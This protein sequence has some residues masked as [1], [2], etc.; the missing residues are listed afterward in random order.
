ME[1]TKDNIL[2]MLDS[3]QV[4]MDILRKEKDISAKMEG[5]IHG[6]EAALNNIRSIVSTNM[7]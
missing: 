3:L 2:K 7:E 1:L 4:G 6:Y 5:Y